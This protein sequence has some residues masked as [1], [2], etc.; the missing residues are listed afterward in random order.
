MAR[1]DL[2]TFEDARAQT[3]A[4]DNLRY[5]FWRARITG[6][7]EALLARVRAIEED[8]DTR[9]VRRVLDGYRAIQEFGY[10]PVRISQIGD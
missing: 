2:E 3:D 7:D 8:Q 5:A 9:E 4:P 1:C 10:C 6:Q